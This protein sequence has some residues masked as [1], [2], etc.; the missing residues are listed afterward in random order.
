M[1]LP[2]ACCLL[3]LPALLGSC[4]REIPCFGDISVDD[5]Y[6]QQ[7]RIED[8]EEVCP[9]HLAP[10]IQ[11][12][13]AGV[14]LD[15]RKLAG[16][17]SLPADS[18]RKVEPLFTDL[19]LYRERWKQLHPAKMFEPH[20]VVSVGSEVDAIGG[21]SLVQSTAFA[22]YP[23]IRVEC[24]GL[25]LELYWAVPGPPQ[26]DGEGPVR[27]TLRVVQ[28][29]NGWFTVSMPDSKPRPADS[30]AKD[31]PGLIAS[32][33]ETCS[34]NGGACAHVLELETNEGSFAEVASLART[35]MYSRAFSKRLPM[36]RL[37]Q[38]ER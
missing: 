23:R 27:E 38:S 21:I 11:A 26:P 30:H 34:A 25:E 4:R 10:K 22:G 8:G 12:S 36:L 37:K 35:L 19:K 18:V 24:P 7:Q 32:V 2:A 28:D 16:R 3:L 31:L 9:Q 17:G 5:L 1:R 20:A 15:G 13:G 29:R 6:R 14:V 33:E